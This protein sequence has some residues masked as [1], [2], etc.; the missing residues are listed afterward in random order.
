[1][2]SLCWPPVMKNEDLSLPLLTFSYTSPLTTSSQTNK[3]TAFAD[4]VT[5]D[6]CVSVDS[7]N[8]ITQFPMT[9]FS[10][11]EALSPT[12]NPTPQNQLLYSLI[13]WGSW[14]LTVVTNSVPASS[15]VCLHAPK[16]TQPGAGQPVPTLPNITFLGFPSVSPRFPCLFPGPEPCFLNPMLSAFV[17]S[18]HILEKLHPR[19][20]S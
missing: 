13:S 7:V 17:D 5:T 6:V 11:L 16:A 2:L 15:P 14:F 18:V 10:L 1:M 19:A 20:S 8:W 9:P 12:P 3:L 4:I